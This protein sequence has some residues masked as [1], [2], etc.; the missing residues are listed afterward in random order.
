MTFGFDL[1]DDGAGGYH[2]V[3]YSMD[4]VYSADTWHESLEDAYATAEEVF[5]IRREQ[6]G[7]P[8]DP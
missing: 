3:F 1:T 4:R 7:A 8:Q 6:W 2:L 5:G